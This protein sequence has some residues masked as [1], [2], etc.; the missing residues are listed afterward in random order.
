MFTIWLFSL[1]DSKTFGESEKIYQIVTWGQTQ[2]HHWYE[3]CYTSEVFLHQVP[4]TGLKRN[5]SICKIP[6]WHQFTFLRVLSVND[7]FFLGGDWFKSHWEDTPD[8]I[9]S[10][11]TGARNTLF[12]PSARQMIT[13]VIYYPGRSKCTSSAH[14]LQ[15][16][17]NKWGQGCDLACERA[18]TSAL[19]LVG[20][21]WT[22][23]QFFQ[24]CGK[25]VARSANVLNTPC[26]WS[27]AQLFRKFYVSAISG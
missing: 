21:S 20:A 2:T 23:F 12:P 22:R 16:L 18:R 10:H 1:C 15:T 3:K 6:E 25:M 9:F 13:I 7:E 5:L 26:H 14:A 8:S 17:S 24:R 11:L 19:D 4:W 27:N